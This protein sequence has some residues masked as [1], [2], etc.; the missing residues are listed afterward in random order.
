MPVAPTYAPAPPEAGSIECRGAAARNMA[1]TASE[2]VELNF[3][4]SSGSHRTYDPYA[5]WLLEH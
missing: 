3:L 4:H 5:L 2:A 1:L